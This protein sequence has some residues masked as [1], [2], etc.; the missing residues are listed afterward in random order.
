[1]SVTECANVKARDDHDQRAKATERDHQA[2]QKEQ[3]VD[4]V[5]DVRRSRP[6]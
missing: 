3:V 6:W 5:E 1:M 4:A 2:E